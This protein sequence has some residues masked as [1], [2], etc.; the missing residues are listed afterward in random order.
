MLAG[1]PSGGPEQSNLLALRG[2]QLAVNSPVGKGGSSS[3]GGIVA[4]VD[5]SA[6]LLSSAL[7]LA[8][9]SLLSLFVCSVCMLHA[10]WRR[11]MARPGGRHLAV[12][13]ML[14]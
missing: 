1:G 14:A 9:F 10:L 4:S 5:S 7:F 11:E 6:F 2:R 13:A 3:S 8:L 12:S